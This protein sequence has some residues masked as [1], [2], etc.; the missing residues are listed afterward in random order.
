VETLERSLNKMQ[1]AEVE[2]VKAIPDYKKKLVKEIAEK[3]K[4]SKTVLVASIKGL[5]TAKFQ[6]IKKKL[7][8][9]VEIV[10]AKKSIVLRAIGEVEKGALQNLKNLVGADV[11]LMFSELDSFE[12]A[13]L[14]LDNQTSAKAKAGD[15]APKDIEVEPGPTELM[16]GP[17]ISELGSVG[18]KV[19]VEGGKLA[20]KQ[21]TVIVKKDEVIDEKVASVMGKLKIAPMKVGFIPVGAYD[22]RADTVYSEMKIDKVGT[23]EELRVAISKSFGFAVNIGY[24][25]TET[26]KYFIAKAGMEEKALEKKVGE[27]SGGEEMINDKSDAVGDSDGTGEE[28]AGEEEKEEESKPEEE[29]KD[30]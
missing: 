2:R 8:D 12:L 5:P 17:A 6:L 25:S 3:M 15:I 4:S 28:K 29:K 7:K 19:A 30:E 21:G 18:L 11:V 26:V 27:K 9:K 23:L 22:S 13:G 14:L 24:V 10:V 1:A 20:I 16:P